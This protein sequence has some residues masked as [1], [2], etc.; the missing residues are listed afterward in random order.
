LKKSIFGFL[1]SAHFDLIL[2]PAVEELTVHNWHKDFTQPVI[3]LLR[4]VVYVQQQG[5]NV[6]VT[7]LA[8]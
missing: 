3:A 1:S 7:D 6:L 8:P 2:L 5:I 4:E